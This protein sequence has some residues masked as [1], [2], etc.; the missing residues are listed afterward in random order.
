LRQGET[1]KRPKQRTCIVPRFLSFQKA[2]KASARDIWPWRFIGGAPRSVATRSRHHQLQNCDLA[3][4]FREPDAVSGQSAFSLWENMQAPRKTLTIPR[5]LQAR[6]SEEEQRPN[7]TLAQ[8]LAIPVTNRQGKPAG[9]IT[10]RSTWTHVVESMWK[11]CGRAAPAAPNL[12]QKCGLLCR[13]KC[14]CDT[15]RTLTSMLTFRSGG[16]PAGAPGDRLTSG[17]EAHV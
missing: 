4:T 14:S 10:L 2:P 17:R 15:F 3:S 8:T 11:R 9:K 1:I 12:P 5:R 6:G 16:A 13:V 7:S